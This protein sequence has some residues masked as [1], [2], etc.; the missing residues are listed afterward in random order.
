MSRIAT[1]AFG[2]LIVVTGAAIAQQ[3]APEA[4]ANSPATPQAPSTA[5]NIQTVSVMDIEELPT[6]SQKQVEAIVAK[7]SDD[8][9]QK[10]RSS[11][12]MFPE[13]R[14]ALEEKGLNENHVIAANVSAGGALTLITQ[15]AS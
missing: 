9:L 3:Q 12:K 13:A 5:P 1:L 8:E 2:A 7:R 10:L 14:Q 15:K 11:I 6:E 4:P